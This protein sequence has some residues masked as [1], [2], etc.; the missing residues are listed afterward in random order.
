[1]SAWTGN[2]PVKPG[3]YWWKDLD[4]PGNPIVVSVVNDGYGL[5]VYGMDEYSRRLYETRGEWQGPI[6]PKE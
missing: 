6:L 1:M 5:T 2:K 3:Y 4:R